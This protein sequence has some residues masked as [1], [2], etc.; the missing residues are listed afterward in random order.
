MSLL[1]EPPIV[2]RG[3]LS[4]ADVL[5]ANRM[6]KSNKKRMA[7]ASAYIFLAS[8]AA[9]VSLA[10]RTYDE[11]WSNWILIGA[12]VVFPAVYFIPLLIGRYR[13][14]QAWK[15]KVDVFRQVDTTITSDGLV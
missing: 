10:V 13:L 3:E 11:N 2:L 12:A 14:L 8:L 7:V 5:T 4:M 9:S 15:Q 1:L 6:L